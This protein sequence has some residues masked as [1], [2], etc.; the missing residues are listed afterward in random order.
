MVVVVVRY[1]YS[2]LPRSS[3]THLRGAIVAPI[4]GTIVGCV[5]YDTAVFTGGESPINYRWPTQ[6]EAL[7]QLRGKRRSLHDHIHAHAKL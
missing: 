6:K 1:L 5:I 3:L 2:S 7:D 4:A